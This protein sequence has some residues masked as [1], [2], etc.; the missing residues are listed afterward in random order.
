MDTKK[1]I[2]GMDEAGRGPWAGP[3]IAA[4]VIL[5]HRIK[6]PGLTD[7]KKLTKAQR[8]TLFN[9]IRSKA[10]YG[11]GMASNQEIDK[12]GLIPATNLAF[13]RALNALT[14][15]PDHLLIDGRDKWKLPI[16]YETIIKGDT[17]IRAISAASIIAKVTRDGL[18][19]RFALEYPQYKFERH[20]GYGTRLHAEA[21]SKHGVSLLH[22]KSYQPVKAHL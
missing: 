21:L 6:L 16:P 4:A 13:L 14:I 8:E 10:W 2:A 17:K 3:V 9:L 11:V 7:S 19:E 18:M 12:N 5:P 22:R 20:K 1:I 15:K